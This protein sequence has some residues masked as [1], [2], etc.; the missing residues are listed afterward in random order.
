[1]T[2]KGSA[3]IAGAFEHPGRELPDKSLAQI[4]AEVALGALADAGL[5]LDDV[6]GFFCGNDAAGAGWV[7]MAD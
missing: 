2:L 3:L 4:H 5:T 1:M 7:S 6:D